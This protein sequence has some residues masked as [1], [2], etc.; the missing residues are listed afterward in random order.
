MVVTT[1]V[2]I[3]TPVDIPTFTAGST[4]PISFSA[5]KADQTKSSQVA[6]VI[7]DVDGNQASCT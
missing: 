7:T 2:N 4:A 3:T 1:A 6:V 5:L